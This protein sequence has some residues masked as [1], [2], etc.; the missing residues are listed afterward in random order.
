[1]HIPILLEDIIILLGF[2]VIV[3]LL[4][5]RLKIPSVLGFLITGVL[6]G[7]FGLGLISSIKEIEII[8]E[9]GVILLLFVIGME[10]SIKQ[11]R[12]MRKTVFIGGLF[13]VGVSVILAMFLSKFMGF[14]W[15]KSVFIGFLFSLS[16]TAL[17]LKIL[18]DRNE[19]SEQH[20]KNALGILIFQDIIVVPMMLITPLIAGEGGNIGIEIVTLLAK[21]VVV[22]IVTYILARYVVPRLLLAVVRTKNQELFLLTTISICFAVTFLTAKAGLSLALG[23]FIAG[24]I[25]SESEYSHKATST[26][27]P[28]KILFTSIFFISIG[29]M[30]DLHFVIY[31]IAVI[32]ILVL[33]VFVVK[34][35]VAGVAVYL[36]KYPTKTVI[37]TGLTL[38]QIG[39]FSFILSKVGIKYGLLTQETNQYFLSV[40]IFTMFMTPFIIQ[41]SDKISSKLLNVFSKGNSKDQNIKVSV[42][43]ETDKLKN[44]LVIIGF[45]E[46]GKN[47]ARIAREVDI[48]YI[49]IDSDIDVVNEAKKENEPII[50]GDATDEHILN[51]AC[52][53]NARIAIIAFTKHKEAL[54]IISTIR[55]LSQTVHLI[56]KTKSDNYI[57]EYI[58]YGADDVVSE[59]IETTIE[60]ASH[61]LRN[62]LVPIH[63]LDTIINKFK[64]DNY[65][66]LRS[67]DEI[68]SQI[69]V[70]QLPELNIVNL[71]V[72]A[73]SGSVVGKTIKDSDIRNK[74]GVSILAIIRNEKMINK[75]TLDE[76]ILQNDTLYIS[77]DNEHIEEFNKAIG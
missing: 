6:I 65:K 14:E 52:L 64:E 9:I 11:L 44:H 50:F 1:M 55:S 12:N 27:I 21:T 7:P 60:I 29:M 68:P 70:N 35:I 75:I 13:Q 20:G 49:I 56:I 18:Q 41:Y 46:A 61:V 28:F 5:Q 39:E 42:S 48:S 51:L 15:D 8:A 76:K 22:V 24:L 17:V 40:T 23:S 59:K 36:L 67:N 33:L 63:Q 77:G 71:H 47:V 26:I 19:I 25:I 10:L 38:F 72:M 3:V 32:L 34:S 57:E 73:D 43:L 4:M 66:V 37:M 74:F 62:Y 53:K 54:N 16:S 2:S 30:L 58:E 45:C 69:H 31:N